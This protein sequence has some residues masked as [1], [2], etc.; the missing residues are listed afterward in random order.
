MPGEAELVAR[1]RGTR[2]APA[3]SGVG[4][5]GC[6]GERAVRDRVRDL[7]IGGVC[8]DVG[9]GDE[10]CSESEDRVLV[11]RRRGGDE[12]DD[13][14]VVDGVDGDGDGRSVGAS[15]AG[16]VVAE[17]GD[18]DGEDVR[19]VVV[20]VSLVAE[21]GEVAVD[22]CKRASEDEGGSGGAGRRATCVM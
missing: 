7:D 22:A 6:E 8:V 20:G 17:V 14:R 11:G 19:A 5:R 2:A 16:A 3:T 13:G 12:G 1:R 21:R 15:A 9:K 18:V 10:A 4:V